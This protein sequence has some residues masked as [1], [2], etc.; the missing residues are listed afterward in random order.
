VDR[1]CGLVS[2]L[3]DKGYTFTPLGDSNV[4]G[5][6]VAGVK[7]ASEGNPDVLLYFDKGTGLLAKSSF[8]GIDAS[9]N[10]EALMEAYYRDYH[11]VDNAA[12]AE[13][14]LRAANRSVQNEDLLAYLRDNMPSA[15]T[16]TEIE[17]L[18]DRLGN[19][20]FV[21]RQQATSA[22]MKHG[23]KAG[24]LLQKA[25]SNSDIEVSRRAAACLESLEPECQIAA[26]VVRLA[27]LRKIAAP[28]TL[29]A[30]FPWAPN[31][32]VRR[33]VEDA[34]FNMV[35]K[36]DRPDAFWEKALQSDEPRIKQIAAAALGKDDAY[37]KQPGRRLFIEGVRVPRSSSTFVDGQKRLDLETLERIYFNSVEESLFAEPLDEQN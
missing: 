23:I 18:I 31:E 36:Q 37:F 22:L 19:A 25:R 1:V 3:R 6:P 20:S 11:L 14:A 5:K 32:T 7:V 16:R 30:Y 13:K 9:S 29:I 27:G 10:R 15:A 21:I 17:T 34:L 8:R 12:E 4:E 28:E 2:L 33:E 35:R 24:A 26:C